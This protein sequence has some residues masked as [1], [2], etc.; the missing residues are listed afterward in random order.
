MYKY[1]AE[2]IEF[3][4]ELEKQF[5]ILQLRVYAY[6]YKDYLS[7]I[8]SIEGSKIKERLTLA[9]VGYSTNG[10]IILTQNNETYGDRIVTN[11]IS[12]KVFFE[13]YPFKFLCWDS[14]VSKISK[15]KIYPVGV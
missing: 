15:I 5:G 6:K 9:L 14:D 11:V 10:D 13:G 12:P 1:P 8:G 7:V 4:S 2:T 3:D